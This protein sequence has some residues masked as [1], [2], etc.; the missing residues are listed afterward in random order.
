MA[1]G[2]GGGLGRALTVTTGKAKGR[3]G[4]AKYWVILEG[5]FLEASQCCLF[6]VYATWTQ[7]LPFVAGGFDTSHFPPG[8]HNYR[9]FR[10]LGSL[11]AGTGAGAA[12]GY[13]ES[14]ASARWSLTSGDVRAGLEHAF[15]PN[16]SRQAARIEA[17]WQCRRAGRNAAFEFARARQ[18][19]RVETARVETA[20]VEAGRVEGMR[21]E[22]ARVLAAAAAAAAAAAPAEA[23]ADQS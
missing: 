17:S 8:H 9:G 3:G 2:S 21:I 13:L 18:Q 12:F 6:V 5:M 16:G 20:R 19:A 10:E 7:V 15:G 1:G 4:S 11:A 14:V 22:S 23:L